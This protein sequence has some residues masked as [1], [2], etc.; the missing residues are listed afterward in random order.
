MAGLEGSEPGGGPA[1]KSGL[2]HQPQKGFGKVWADNAEV[3]RRLGFALTAD[4]TR[5]PITVQ[6]FERGLML[7]SDLGA[8]VRL[9]LLPE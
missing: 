9:R 1:E 5:G 3:Q 2:F 6:S 8:P 7:A 4:E